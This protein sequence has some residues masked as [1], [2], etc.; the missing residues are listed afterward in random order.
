MNSTGLDAFSKRLDDE[1]EKPVEGEKVVD[2]V[3]ASVEANTFARRGREL[4][5]R[6]CARLDGREAPVPT[7][8]PSINARM[9][10]G[11]WPGMHVLVGGTGTGKSQW[12]LQ[13]AIAA[14]RAKTPVP[15]LLLSLELD[16]LGIFTRAVAHVDRDRDPTSKLKWSSLYTGLQGD[17]TDADRERANKAMFDALPELDALP[18][19]WVEAPPHGLPHSKIVELVA[20]LRACYPQ[21]PAHD[22]VL[23][24]VDFLQL[25]AGDDPREEPISR[26]S[27][28]AYQCR[29][30]ARDHN[31]VVLV[32]SSMSRENSKHSVVEDRTKDAPKGRAPAWELVGMGKESGDVEY[33]ADSV[34]VL[35]REAYAEDAPFLPGG[36]AVWCAVAKCRAGAPGWHEL[37][38]DGSRFSEPRE[39]TDAASVGTSEPTEKPLRGKALK[40]AMKKKRSS[41]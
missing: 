17:H 25:I 3:V 13:V 40:D 30:V 18:L 5:N 4:F 22:P 7:P 34:T 33:S 35:C 24:V 37:R 21:R 29:Q 26:V 31:A 14:A 36:R 8:W 32:L 23:V 38:F 20:A 6:A 11:L 15:V 2:P 28:A 12:A 27:R 41:K 19:H 10:G 1:E 16:A 39:E 9:G